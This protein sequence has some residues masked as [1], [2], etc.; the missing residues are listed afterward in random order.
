MQVKGVLFQIKWNN[1]YT[2]PPSGAS[3]VLA[4]IFLPDATDGK[5][6]PEILAI[7]VT[8]GGGYSLAFRAIPPPPSQLPVETLARVRRKR[9]ER[10]VRAKA[11]LF[12]N[13]FIA[14][15]L[16]RKPDYYDGVTDP[17]I[18]ARRQLAL[19][20]GRAERERLFARP[21][22]LIVYGAEPEACRRRADQIRREFLE[23]QERAR[24]KRELESA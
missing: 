18:E 24:N 2:T 16:A 6:P 13:E 8:P 4:E 15:E 7:P 10:R 9:L 22:V 5:P 20:Q 17:D 11:P 23:N 14:D 19:E 3:R 21:N 1:P 12:A